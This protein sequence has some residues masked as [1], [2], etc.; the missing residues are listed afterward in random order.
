MNSW[1]LASV[2]VELVANSFESEANSKHRCFRV[3]NLLKEE[4]QQFVKLWEKRANSIE[5]EDVKLIAA[6]SLGGEIPSSYI[7]EEGKSI[8]FYR[9]HNESGLVY[10]ETEDQSDAQGLQNFFTLRDS[11]FLDASFD[12]AAGSYNSV[13][14]LISAMAWKSLGKT[15]EP[16]SMMLSRLEEIIKLIH[17][18]IEPIPVRK[19]IKYSY[20]VALD[21]SNDEYAVDEEKANE[22]IGSLL[23]HL[24]I[25][26][27]RNWRNADS[28][29][30]SRRRLE[31]NIRYSDL[32]TT[33]GEADPLALIEL[34]KRKQFI[35]ENGD[36]YPIKENGIWR[37]LCEKYVNNQTNDTL[38]QI[39]YGIFMQLFQKDSAGIQLGERVRLELEHSNSERLSELEEMDVIHGLN[40]K[41]QPDAERFL[42]TVAKEGLTALADLISLR[43]RRMIERVAYPRPHECENPIVETV[44]QLQRFKQS[45]DTGNIVT[46]SIEFAGDRDVL[47]PSVGLFSFLYGSTLKTI[48]EASQAA[49]CQYEFTVDNELFL[50]KKPLHSFCS[51]GSEDDV[52]D[53]INWEPVPLRWIARNES[54]EIVDISDVANWR[55]SS[56]QHMVLFWLLLAEPDSPSIKGIGGCLASDEIKLNGTHWLIPFVM[57]TTNVANIPTDKKYISIGQNEITDQ[58]I[59]SKYEL[60]EN[61]ISEGLSIDAINNHFDRWSTLLKE[62]RDTFVPNGIRIPIIDSILMADS[63]SFS[64]TD[65]IYFPTHPL[66]LRWISSYLD[67]SRKLLLNSLSNSLGFAGQDGEPY[68]DWLERRCPR[69]IPPVAINT[70][71]ELL[72]ARSE[73]AWFEHFAKLENGSQG[74]G[75]DQ[76]ALSAICAKVCSYVDAHPYK[77]DGLSILLILPPSDLTASELIEH[78]FRTTLK[79]GNVEVT[80]AAPRIRWEKIAKAVES[81]GVSNTL[82]RRKKLFP[83]QNVTFIEFDTGSS[84]ETAISECNFD[85]G[86]VMNVLDRAM[87]PQHN[88]EPLTQEPGQFDVL[89]DRTTRID[90]TGEDGATS[91]VMRPRAPDLALD[92]W[93]TLVVRSNRCRPISPLQP[94]NTD[95][96]ELRLNFSGLASLFNTMHQHC[97]WVITLERHISR[98][99]IESIEAGA[100]DVLSIQDGIGANGLG[101]L[102]V[103]SRTGR[104]LVESRLSRKLRKLVHDAGQADNLEHLASVIYDE[105]RWTSPHLALNAMG[106][107]R[108]TEEI[109]G[110]AVARALADQMYPLPNSEGFAVWISLDEHVEWFGG[111]GSTRAD[112]CRLTFSMD[113]SEHVGLDVLV[114][115][116]KLRQSFDPHGIQQAKQT[117]QFMADILDTEG[118]NN[119]LSKIDGKFW[120]EK[121]FSAIDMCADQARITFSHIGSRTDESKGSLLSHIRTMFRNGTY[122]L[123]SLNSMYSICL[124]ENQSHEIEYQRVD[125]VM[126]V[127]TTNLHILPLLRKSSL[128]VPVND[129]TLS[130]IQDNHLIANDT[131]QN[132]NNVGLEHQEIKILNNATVAEASSSVKRVSM[133]REQVQRMYEEIL[134][135]FD[136]Y[137]ISVQSAK[138]EDKPIIEGPA[139]ILFKVRPR[140]GVDP[141]KIYEK[142]DALKLHLQLENEQSVYFGIDKG[143]VTIDVP[144]SE[145]QRYFVDAH[146]IW[147]DWQRPLEALATPLGEDRFGQ[148]VDLNFSSSNSPHLLIGGTTGSGK[149]EAL[150]T[151]L[152]GLVKFYSKEELRLLLVDPKGTELNM[153]AR[154]DHLEGAIGWDDQDAITLLK[155]AVDE[156]ERRYSAF[157]EKKVRTL[158]DFNKI[159]SQQNKI[160]WWIIVLDEY[161]DLTSDPQ[162]KKEI[163]NQL[164]RLAQKARAS[165]IHIII[166]TQKPSGDVI[167]TNLRANLPAQLALR[168]KSGIESRV[169]MDETGAESLNGKGDAYLKSEGRIKRVQCARVA[170]DKSE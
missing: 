29:G 76:E 84:L 3:K 81:T 158:S 74:F 144:K 126:V 62:V 58:F 140:P 50:P 110:L 88:T 112:M 11:N 109:L 122:S 78:L 105:T 22:L 10:L 15:S 61:I 54:G 82:E 87:Q 42:S 38:S 2:A 49:D 90:S 142:A 135:C 137:G 52:N 28:E 8:T 48:S 55:P 125:D 43:T 70:D 107:S 34:I 60:H 65:R 118:G 26:P 123:K 164:K 46:I 18:E 17:P 83:A 111:R 151:I 25:F 146:D 103:S 40:Q 157:K 31:L 30:K 67:E 108:V 6:S 131:S 69:E 134:S 73:T 19:F 63:I 32:R 12:T 138:L 130:S 4:A 97:H 124:W 80:I 149:S 153:F 160:P 7:A 132:P 154:F 161:A 13:F 170:S 51:L 71:G 66:K 9:N 148:V 75:D 77:K 1:I 101:T 166:A 129:L 106:V 79:G 133:S 159:S 37:S 169:I 24:D 92:S 91:I 141:K 117:R 53:E 98:R 155:N 57:G 85:I 127:R 89:F 47:T 119:S 147:S 114:I 45:T 168:V 150:N 104:V 163:E 56:M 99:Q 72:Y 14:K 35:N 139:S 162:M 5:L 165:G 143:Y 36:K 96:I 116:G 121:V 145:E 102:V 95:F 59:N 16:P 39:P 115:E 33:N 64:D 156:M 41:Q 113:E 152:Y 68:L 21:W 44:R 128:N 93:G 27:D 120:R 100:P 23:W 94:E 136:A 86:I 167:S 20:N